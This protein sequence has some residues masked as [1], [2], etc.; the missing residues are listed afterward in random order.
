MIASVLGRLLREGWLNVVGGCCGTRPKHIA[1]IA[2][3]A[4]AS[5]PRRVP[6]HSRTF[7]SGVEWLEVEESNRPVLVGERTNVIGSRA[8]K[9]LIQAEKFE[10]GS[11]IARRQV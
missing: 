10:E 11:E 6:S 7:L 8:F 2:A 9:E 5:A 4:A 1:A 3:A